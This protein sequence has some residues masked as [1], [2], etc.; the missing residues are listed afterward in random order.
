MIQRPTSTSKKLSSKVQL[1]NGHYVIRIIDE[2]FGPSKSS[3]NKMFTL[4]AEIV[5]PDVAEDALGNT[6]EVA[7]TEFVMYYPI[8][9]DDPKKLD[10]AIERLYDLY[11]KIGYAVPAGGI[12]EEKP[13]LPFA[14]AIK[15]GKPIQLDAILYGKKTV[16]LDNKRK[17]ILIGGKE[18]INYQIQVDSIHGLNTDEVN[19][20]Y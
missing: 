12:D 10:N 7:A 3:G 1:P 2:V 13:Y 11:D 8:E 6:I 19:K 9:N 14:E 15:A 5:S 16:Q 4:T 18:V 20:P 17:P